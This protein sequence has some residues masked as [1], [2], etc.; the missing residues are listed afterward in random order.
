VQNA[1][2]GIGHVEPILMASGAMSFPIVT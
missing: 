1:I 2:A